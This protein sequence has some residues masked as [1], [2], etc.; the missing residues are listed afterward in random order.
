MCFLEIQK[1]AEAS[2]TIRLRDSAKLGMVAIGN[3]DFGN[4]TFYVPNSSRPIQL[5]LSL[6][7]SYKQLT[8]YQMVTG[9]RAARA[10]QNPGQTRSE[11]EWFCHA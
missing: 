9:R 11:N 10:A 8:L 3:A 6:F 1:G 2:M 4:P 5:F 7:G